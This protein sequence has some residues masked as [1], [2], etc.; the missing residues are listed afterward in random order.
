M[1]CIYGHRVHAHDFC[2]RQKRALE[3]L[4]LGSL[5]VVARPTWVLKLDLGSLK[6]Q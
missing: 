5:A 4:K 6:E 3:L 2:R 1:M